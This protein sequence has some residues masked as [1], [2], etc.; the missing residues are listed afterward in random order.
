MEAPLKPQDA[1]DITIQI[2]SALV[3]AHE[4]GIIH[5][6]I[7]PENVMILREG[8]IKLLDFGLAKLVIDKDAKV[9]MSAPTVLN[10]K[11]KPGAVMGTTSYMSPEQARGLEL[12]PRTDIFSLGVVLHEMVTGRLP[13][14]GTNTCEIVSSILSDKEVPR[15]G[16]GAPEEL[17]RIAS[18]AL[19]KPRDS[20]YQTTKDLLI[21]LQNLKENLRFDA[22]AGK[23][24]ETVVPTKTVTP[25]QTNTIKHN[26]VVKLLLVI[27]IVSVIVATV[28]YLAGT[29]SEVAIQSIAV[30]PLVNENKDP[31]T[32]YL[33]DGISK[34]S[35]T[36]CHNCPT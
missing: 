34:Q 18:K 25:V 23:S 26:P 33:S 1:I 17:E 27:A 29:K 11:T 16:V 22:T 30:L 24:S 19:S 4:A 32:E 28:L 31:N 7:K 12:D 21:D 20:R 15:L 10:V 35:L 8:I 36:A 2:A 9:D 5:R 6:D 14:E 13:F 3:R